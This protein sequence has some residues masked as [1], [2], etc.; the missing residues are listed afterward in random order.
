MTVRELADTGV[1]LNV[2]SWV[3]N[4]DYSEIRWD[5][6]ERIRVALDQ[7]GITIPYPKLEVHM[8]DVKAPRPTQSET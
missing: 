2:R 8:A 3:N 6:S 7:N 1:D 4:A 5:L